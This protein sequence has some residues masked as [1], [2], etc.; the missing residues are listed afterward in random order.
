[1]GS[2]LTT[3]K[4]KVLKTHCFASG[5]QIGMCERMKPAQCQ[6]VNKQNLLSQSGLPL[7]NGAV[8]AARGINSAFS[9]LI[10]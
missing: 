9:R 8:G 1:M 4:V 5:T 6:W 3:V 2:L 10:S 7:L